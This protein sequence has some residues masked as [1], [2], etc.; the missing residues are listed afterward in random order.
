LIGAGIGQTI[1]TS[2][3]WAPNPDYNIV[4]EQSLISFAPDNPAENPPFRLSGMTI[5]CTYKCQ[6][7]LLR[8][9]T[10]ALCDKIRIDHIHIYNA[11]WAL[12]RFGTVYGVMDNCIV[13]GGLDHAGLH[14]YWTSTPYNF[15]G[16]DNFYF[17]DNEWGGVVDEFNSA[18]NESPRYCI[19]YNRIIG[20]RITGDGI[21]PLCDLHG[22]QG[23]SGHSASQ[24]AEIYENTITMGSKVICLLD[25]RG[26]K[27]LCFNNYITSSDTA[28]TK[29]RE[30]EN[31][32]LMPPAN[33]LISGQPQHVSESYYWGNRLNGSIIINP[34]IDEIVNYGGSIGLVPQEDREF[35][36]EK[37][38]F[39]G[40]SGI[41]V[42]LLAGRPSTGTKGVAYWAT[43][44]KTLYI[45][46]DTNSWVEY[47]RPYAYPH[48]LRNIL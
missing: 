30:E 46:R 47:Y 14:S 34:Y 11:D 22:N 38:Q 13:V 7:I 29:V 9:E 5:N 33:N 19:R 36:C 43:D 6:G 42:G 8:N 15:G 37:A 26:G 44:T 16:S 39:N 32:N 3:Y 48:P 45:C 27:V 12:T 40:T 2:N 17:E 4:P 23:S 10:E 21:R 1:I 41:G 24:G 18:G 35:W 25:Q 28:V 31:D 20:D